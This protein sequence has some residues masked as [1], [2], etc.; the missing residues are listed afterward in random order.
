MRTLQSCCT[1]AFCACFLVCAAQAQQL[2]AE[3]LRQMLQP[4]SEAPLQ[5]PSAPAVKQSPLQAAGAPV[6]QPDPAQWRVPTVSSSPPGDATTQSYPATVATPP[7]RLAQ[8][9]PGEEGLA[10]IIA[11]WPRAQGA[12]AVERFRDGFAMAGERV[13]DPEG[14]IVLY[15][16]DSATGNA[17]YMLQGPAGQMVVKLMRYRSGAP[18]PIAR[19][20]RTNGQWSVETSSGVRVAGGRLTLSPTGFIVARDNAL[21]QYIAGD[22]LHSYGLPETHT[23]AA[24][25]N[26][27]I[28]ATGWLLLE[29]RQEAQGRDGTGAGRSNIGNFLGAIRSLGAAIG[30]NKADT[31][32]ALYQL[33]TNKTVP[34]GIAV[35]ENQISIMS[36]CRQR[37]R[38][39][40]ICDQAD[41]VESLYGQD[42]R[43]NRAHYFWRVMW[44]NT[45]RGPVA[46]IME[47]GIT[48]I[49]AIELT[50]DR[51]AP[52]FE[53][54]LGIG[55][56][57]ASQSLDGRVVVRA[58]LGLETSKNEDVA[59]LF[60][61]SAPTGNPQ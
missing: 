48:K 38:W 3:Q 17:T 7:R 50:T 60:A 35:S 42:G 24:H 56:W 27:D 30:L 32:Y 52:V 59:S 45:E 18:V 47:D 20:S 51:R 1:P 61:G 33:G 6:R 23:L 19:A 29:K 40:A 53:R 21:F 8:P 57:S 34:I 15:A 54:G 31:D 26:G 49:E 11:A 28:S 55:D 39:V 4:R 36:Q 46:L 16:A 22:G 9:Q 10:R 25:Q 44:F 14:R 43:P 12:F 58:Q 2:N 41:Q 5:H 13:L 37:N